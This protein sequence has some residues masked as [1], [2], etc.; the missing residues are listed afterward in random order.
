MNAAQ[1]TFRA[2][3]MNLCFNV[4]DACSLTDIEALR[5]DARMILNEMGV[6]TP[7][8]PQEDWRDLL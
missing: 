8:T 4:A 7:D 3:V 5:A 6:V 2:H 1:H